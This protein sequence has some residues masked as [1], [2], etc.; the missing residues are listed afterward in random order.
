M[1]YKKI[2]MALALAFNAA[3]AS[4]DLRLLNNVEQ[5]ADEDYDVTEAVP[6]ICDLFPN[7]IGCDPEDPEEP[8]EETEDAVK[9]LKC[10]EKATHR[11]A[12]CWLRSN[13]YQ[14]GGRRDKLDDL[15]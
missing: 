13:T 8:M 11:G 2:T 5:A 3:K 12:R 14:A 1:S 4:Q 7:D 9:E 10:R 6:A 15:W